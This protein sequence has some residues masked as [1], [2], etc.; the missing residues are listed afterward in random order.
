MDYSQL[1]EA[2]GRFETGVILPVVVGL[3]FGYLFLKWIVEKR[4]KK[5]KVN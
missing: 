1:G 3:Y 4:R 2:V 5:K